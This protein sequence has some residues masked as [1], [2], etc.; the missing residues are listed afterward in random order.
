LESDPI[1][2]EGGIN[3]YAYV[4]GNPLRSSDPT[5]LAPPGRT[6]PSPLPPGPFTFPSNPSQWSHDFALQI[7]SAVDSAVEAVK[8]ACEGK[9]RPCKT[10]SGRIVP[11]GTIGYRPLEVIPPT[12]KQH[13]VYGSHHNIFKANQYPYPKCDCF[14]AKQNWVA[15]PTELLPE[16]IPIEPFVN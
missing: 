8:Q 2:L 5:G 9:C 4:D 13:G 14:W 6:A 1:G 16:W 15:T 3:T 7:E 10:V 11:V 12:E